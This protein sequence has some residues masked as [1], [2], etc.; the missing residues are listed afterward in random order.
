[1]MF[2]IVIIICIC[3]VSMRKNKY[4]GLTCTNPTFGPLPLE[5]KYHSQ[6]KE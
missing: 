4:N 1:M 6:Q 3:F 2:A 5:L